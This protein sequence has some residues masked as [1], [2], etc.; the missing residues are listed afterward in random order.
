MNPVGVQFSSDKV[1][2]DVKVVVVEVEVVVIQYSRNLGSRNG[3]GLF[4]LD[5]RNSSSTSYE[6]NKKKYLVFCQCHNMELLFNF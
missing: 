4:L 2:V 6:L 3:E 1:K 5:S